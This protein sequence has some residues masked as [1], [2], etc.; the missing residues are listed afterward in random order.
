MKIYGNESPFFFLSLFIQKLEF[1][2][3][4]VLKLFLSINL[5]LKLLIVTI[6]FFNFYISA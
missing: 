6:E 5:I 3:L 1:I 4:K 2:I